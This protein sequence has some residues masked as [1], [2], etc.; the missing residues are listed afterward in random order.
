[1][2]RIGIL[3]DI[4][5]GKSF[6]AKQFGYP[7]FN[8]DKEVAEIYKKSKKCYRKLKK[9]LP[10]YIISFPIDKTEISKAIIHNPS[11]IKKITSIVHP[12]VRIKMNYFMSKNRKKKFVILDIPL[13]IEKKLNRKKDILIFVDAKK[14]NIN[15]RLLKRP[16]FKPKIT[17]KL[18]ILQL[19]LEYKKK[20]SHFI[21]KN[22][23]NKKTTKKIVKTI[24]KKILL[25]ARSYS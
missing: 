9:L 5:S 10:K 2:I 19:P 25:N 22:Y 14:K 16:N 18:K 23:Y 11:N 12:E 3:G 7:V 1:M 24:L 8:A 13:L 6:V 17:K 21:I 15:K 20:K 4:G